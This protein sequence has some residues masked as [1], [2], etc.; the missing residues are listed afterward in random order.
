MSY[1]TP[2]QRIEALRPYNPDQ[3]DRFIQVV[4][5]VRVP[6]SAVVEGAY[7]PNGVPNQ[8]LL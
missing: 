8:Q 4:L 3:L 1:Q 6:R 5:G 2:A 7:R